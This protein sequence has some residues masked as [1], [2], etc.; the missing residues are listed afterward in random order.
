MMLT[1]GDQGAFAAAL[2]P[3]P[4]MIWAPESDIGMPKAGVDQFIATVRPAY[5]RAGAEKSF[6]VHQPPGEHEFTLAAFDAMAD[7]FRTAFMR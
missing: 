2:A 6:V 5:A 7:F 4:L 1:H 3:R